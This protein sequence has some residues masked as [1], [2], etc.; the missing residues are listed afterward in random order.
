MQAC[1][2]RPMLPLARCRRCGAMGLSRGVSQHAHTSHIRSLRTFSL[3]PS[4]YRHPPARAQ[5]PPLLHT[6]PASWRTLH[7]AG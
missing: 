4:L 7:R 1:K 5:P 6:G 2:E 3:F